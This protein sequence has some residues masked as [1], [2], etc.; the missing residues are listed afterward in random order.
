MP[1]EKRKGS[2][3]EHVMVDVNKVCPQTMFILVE[4]VVYNA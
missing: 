3:N 4:E 1:E 2:A